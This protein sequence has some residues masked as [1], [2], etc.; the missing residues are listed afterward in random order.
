MQ[1]I[2]TCLELV[3]TLIFSFLY[4]VRVRRHNRTEVV[5]DAHMYLQ[6]ALYSNPDTS[7]RWEV[8]NR[9]T[10]LSPSSDLRHPA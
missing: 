7:L 1:V 5:P 6:S 2:I 10:V 9:S 3:V 8:L 4:I